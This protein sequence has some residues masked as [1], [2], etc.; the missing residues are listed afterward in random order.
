VII[1]TVL[2]AVLAIFFAGRFAIER[3]RRKELT[4]TGR[5]PIATARL[6][7]IDDAFATGPFGPGL[8]TAVTFVG[9]GHLEV[10]GGTSDSE[11]W[12]L[13]V[14]AK[15]AK[16]LFEFG[17]CTGKTTFLWAQNSLPDA[18]VVTLTLPPADV[19]RYTH[20]AGDS[21]QDERAALRESRFVDFMYSGT[22]VAHKVVQLYGDSKTIALT[23]WR[24]QC[25][26]VF[27]DGSHAYSY[28]QSDSASAMDL[29]RPGGIILWHDYAG[30]R[31]SPGVYR[32]LNELAT[33]LPLR[34]IAGTSLVVYRKPPSMIQAR[35]MS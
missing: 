27:V 10:E 23:E 20:A 18:R 30:P 3:R 32:A 31:H 29:A 35:G 25:D 12:I 2:F 4:F 15:N 5:W 33:R 26:V 13:A 17:T 7:E 11:A 22:N 16:L 19:D 34:R 9:K 21:A 6:D 24:E 8:H 28:V 1:L 14:L